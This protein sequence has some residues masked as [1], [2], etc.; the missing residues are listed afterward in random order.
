MPQSE[1]LVSS[2]LKFRSAIE[3]GRGVLCFCLKVLKLF[4][5]M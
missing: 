2:S 4:S 1:K 3:I 5:N